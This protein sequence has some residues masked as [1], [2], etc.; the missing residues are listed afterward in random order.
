M[1]VLFTKFTQLGFAL[2]IVPPAFAVQGASGSVCASASCPNPNN[3]MPI[4][5]AAAATQTAAFPPDCLPEDFVHSLTA[6]RCPVR[7]QKITL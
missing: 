6:T 7:L 2:Y 3:A 5:H 1:R 4:E